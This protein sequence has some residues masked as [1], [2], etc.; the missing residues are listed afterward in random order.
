M[1]VHRNGRGWA[2]VIVLCILMIFFFPATFGPYSVVHGPVSALRPMQAAL[3][4]Q[5]A[6]FQAAV[7]SF[8]T[9]GMIPLLASGSLLLVI[10]GES[11]SA[12]ILG[13]NPPTILRC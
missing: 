3:R 2:I 13:F 10:Q 9:C 5:F 11:F 8:A 6:M 7:G 1:T 12:G 4:L